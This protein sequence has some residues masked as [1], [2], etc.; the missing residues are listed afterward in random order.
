MDVKKME[1]IVDLEPTWE[2]MCK[3]TTSGH[4]KAD[5]LLPACKIADVVRQA[6]KAGHKS[7]TIVFEDDNK[8]R[9][10]VEVKQ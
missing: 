6:Q 7:I 1:E 9:I 4:I 8:I 10:S 3:M 5:L 2:A